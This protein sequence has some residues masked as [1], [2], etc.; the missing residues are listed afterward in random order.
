VWER[1]RDPL[2]AGLVIGL[3]LLLAVAAILAASTSTDSAPGATL[4][5]RLPDTLQGVVLALLAL[6]ALLLLAMQ[7]PRRPSEDSL[8]A[9]RV[10][11]RRSAWSAVLA[12]LPFLVLLV[13]AWHVTRNG[14]LADENHPIDRAISAISG[15]L[16]LLTLAR[17]PPTSV[18]LFDAAMAGLALLFAL[19]VFALMI[20]LTLAEHLTNRRAGR[21][22]AAA[23]GV[24]VERADEDPRAM[25][26]ARAAILRA[27]ARFERALSV[28]RAPRTPAQTPTEVMRV[29]LARFP[30]PAPALARLTALFEL[31]RF[32]DRPLD[33]RA[34]DEACDCLDTVTAVLA[35]S[36]EEGARAR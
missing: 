35:G 4:V 25:P 29:T 28:A 26:D 22:V 1:W 36:R 7:R 32:S 14:W 20:A 6:S 12:L 18:P 23:A 8:L 21:A 11:R 9:D 15:L 24:P 34:R 19:A 31:A 27:Y 33:L 30:L 2:Q 3:G 5:V 17:K 16:D 13:V 10:S